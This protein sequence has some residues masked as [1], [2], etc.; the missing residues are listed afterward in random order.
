MSLS[1]HTAKLIVAK[2]NQRLHYLQNLRI[3]KCSRVAHFLVCY[4]NISDFFVTSVKYSSPVRHCPSHTFLP[5]PQFERWNGHQKN[6]DHGSH[7]VLGMRP[8]PYLQSQGH[9][10][11][12]QKKT[13]PVSICELCRNWFGNRRWTK[14]VRRVSPVGVHWPVVC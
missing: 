11:N 14:R 2:P 4:R 8:G 6:Y 10:M 13:Y 12:M 1:G 9:G 7:C 5:A 3:S